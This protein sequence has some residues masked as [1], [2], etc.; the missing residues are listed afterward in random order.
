METLA[1]LPS[2]GHTARQLYHL[3][4]I[5]NNKVQHIPTAKSSYYSA[6]KHIN[7]ITLGETLTG[8]QVHEFFLNVQAC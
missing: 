7:G 6:N 3:S 4:E 1:S 8:A 2:S 5:L